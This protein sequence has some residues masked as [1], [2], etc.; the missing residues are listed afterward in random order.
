[1]VLQL[2]SGL[3]WLQ[4]ELGTR[5][6]SMLVFHEYNSPLSPHHFWHGDMTELPAHCADQSSSWPNKAWDW[7]S[8]TGQHFLDIQMIE[9]VACS[10]PRRLLD[11][12]YCVLFPPSTTERKSHSSHDRNGVTDQKQSQPQPPPVQQGLGLL[13]SKSK[14]ALGLFLLDGGDEGSVTLP[15]PSTI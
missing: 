6:L 5:H 14:S 12:R 10:Q 8:A 4:E 1:M 13:C 3:G 7:F 15:A 9:I 2:G 11:W